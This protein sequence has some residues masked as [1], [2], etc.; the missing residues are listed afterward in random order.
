[1]LRKQPV[2]GKNQVKVTF[3]LP[4]GHPY[5]KASVVGVFNGWDPAAN[6]FAKRS[7]GTYSTSVLLEAGRRYPFRYLCEGECWVND[8]AADAYEPSGF[9]EDNCV[10]E[11]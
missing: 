9:G 10:V 5:G 2:K 8:P 6:P 4:A 11:T 1:M 7:N 3:I